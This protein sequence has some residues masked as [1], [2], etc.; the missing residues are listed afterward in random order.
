MYIAQYPPTLGQLA[1]GVGVGPEGG[2]AVCLPVA[3]GMLAA[4]A[5]EVQPCHSK[6]IRTTQYRPQMHKMYRRKENNIYTYTV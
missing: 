4:S 6:F 5:S 3:A 2:A 1:A